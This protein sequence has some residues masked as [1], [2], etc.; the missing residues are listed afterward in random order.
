MKNKANYDYSKLSKFII[1][2]GVIF[3]ILSFAVTKYFDISRDGFFY[4]I[5]SGFIVGAIIPLLL[6]IMNKKGIDKFLLKND[7]DKDV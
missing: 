5:I 7:K 1:I 6:A 2:I 4:S 3:G